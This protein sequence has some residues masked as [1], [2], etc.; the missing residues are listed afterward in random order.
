MAETMT[1][2]KVYYYLVHIWDVGPPA[3]DGGGMMKR[4]GE[5]EKT[6]DDE[7]GIIAAA[8]EAGAELIAQD[9]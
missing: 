1:L 5:G 6:V 4:G 9:A 7:N 2:P 8:P 3:G